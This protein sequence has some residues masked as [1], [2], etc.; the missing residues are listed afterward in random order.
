GGTGTGAAP[1]IAKAARNKGIL[2]V[3]IV[4]LPFFIEGKVRENQARQGLEELQQHV[5]SLVVIRNDNIQKIYGSLPIKEAFGKADDILATAAKGIAELI[6]RHGIVNVDFADVKTVM[7]NSGMALMGSAKATGADK[8]T[9][10][11]EQALSS[12]LLNHQ[13]IRGAK[14]ILF[15]LSY[16][17]GDLVSFDQAQE[18]LNLIQKRASKS[19]DGNDANIIW[20]AG[21]QTDLDDEIELTIIATGF[22]LADAT[23]PGAIGKQPQ[24][25]T[26]SG[27][28]PTKQP[29]TP[30][31]DI[32]R[33]PVEA[34]V[35]KLRHKD[36]FDDIDKCSARPSYTTR[37]MHLL[38]GG[39][40]GKVV[41]QPQEPE[42]EEPKAPQNG[43]TLF[44]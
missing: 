1:V 39:K 14:N 31:L 34:T 40:Q 24:P 37:G 23:V 22:D 44:G 33:P 42:R 12:P 26:N 21:E 11:V 19:F 20:G 6:T 17:S 32:K 27:F 38:G 28:T 3:G 8:I 18:A 29:T 35:L 2:T 5:D 9:Q 43:G 16:S 30:K 15:N 4:T 13:D 36:R 25:D 7:Q 41:F 10:V